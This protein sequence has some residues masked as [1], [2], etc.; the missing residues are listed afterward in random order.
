MNSTPY[1]PSPHLSISLKYRHPERSRA[2]SEANRQTQSKD[3]YHP[4]TSRGTEANFQVVVRFFDE[5]E[6]ELRPVPSREAA[7][8]E[9]PARQCR[10]CV[11]DGTTTDGMALSHKRISQ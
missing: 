1:Q 10:G 5:H 2:E 7:A 11:V 4:D 9:S 3:P 8:G 6:T